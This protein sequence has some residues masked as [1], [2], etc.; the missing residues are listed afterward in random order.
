MAGTGG[1][2]P[3]LDI[4]DLVTDAEQDDPDDAVVVELPDATAADYEIEATGRTVADHNESYPADD[5]VVV[6]AFEPGLAEAIDG[7]RFAAPDELRGLVRDH[8][9]RTYAYPESRLDRVGRGVH[10]AVTVRF[11]GA[12]EPVNPGGHGTWG[13][14]IEAGG[15]TLAKERGY[16]GEGEG[17]TNNVAEYTALLEAL[18]HAREEVSAA[19]VDV[20]GDSQLVVRQLRGEYDVNSPRLRPLYER[21]R[22]LLSAFDAARLRWV[23][24]ERNREADRLSRRAYEEHAYA[25]RLERAKAEAMAVEP[26]GD[27]RYRVKGEYEVDLEAG[28]CTCPDFE[29]RGAKCKHL[30]KVELEGEPEPG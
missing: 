24:R 20:R 27:G 17:I 13:F 11:D 14:V 22:R 7:W 30:F 5:P 9:V 23:P 8:E 25:D 1:D 3:A 10:D 21:A 28:T 19:A 12:C 2:A 15:D 18:E 26:L 4:G 29:H 6:V 16:I